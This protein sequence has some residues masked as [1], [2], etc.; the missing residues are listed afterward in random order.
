[1]G[2]H[3]ALDA[4]CHAVHITAKVSHFTLPMDQAFPDARGEN[5]AGQLLCNLAQS[6]KGY[7]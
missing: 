7:G 1:M 3:K 5:A 2:T 4:F 6:A